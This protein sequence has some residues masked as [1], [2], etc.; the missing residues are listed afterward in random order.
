MYND[1]NRSKQAKLLRDQLALKGH[2][3]SHAQCLELLAKLE[4]HRTL[5]VAQAK[6]KHAIV[7]NELA[8]DQARAVMFE[9]L[10]RYQDRFA[11]FLSDIERIELLED[12]G[13]ADSLFRSIF[14]SSNGVKL[15][16]GFGELTSDEIP[17]AYDKL[18]DK[19]RA[20][21]LKRAGSTDAQGE[22]S[23]FEG[24]I[25]DW[26]KFDGE[27]EPGEIRQDYNVSIKRSG[28][29]FYIDIT[30]AGCPATELAGKAQLGVFL[31]VNQ[32]LP[33]VHV[34]NDIWGDQLLTVFGLSSG[35]YL[36]PNSDDSRI[37]MMAPVPGTDLAAH[38]E[39][40][41]MTNNFAYAHRN[42]AH[43]ENSNT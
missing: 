8:H 17:A 13:E 14:R 20:T 43:I 42:N 22:E 19:L 39:W 27:L 7:M 29:R 15:A 35:L 28:V 5:H 36:R 34:T 11:E 24:T 1:Q 16:E 10:G 33:C 2:D 37:R 41:T 26:E 12:A 40:E 18:V 38:H 6:P 30:P 31:E 3:I 4:G 9:S 32:G 23:Y 21:L 25:Q